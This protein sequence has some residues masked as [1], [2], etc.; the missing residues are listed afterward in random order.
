MFHWINVSDILI[1]RSL[2]QEYLNI[3]HSGQQ[4]INKNLSQSR[5]YLFWVKYTKDIT[6]TVENTEKFKYISDVSSYPW[7]ILGSESFY[8]K[9]QDFLVHVD[10]Y[11]LSSWLWGIYIPNSTTW[12]VIKELGILFSGYGRPYLFRSDNSSCYASQELNY[13]CKNG[14]DLFN[15]RHHHTTIRV[16]D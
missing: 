7:H 16:M 4:G 8:Y 2:Q 5:E 6:E 3:I 12:A 15:I 13:S 1:P 9:K 11:S 14:I 10:Y